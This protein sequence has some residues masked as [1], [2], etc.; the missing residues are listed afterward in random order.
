MPPPASLFARHGATIAVVGVLAVIVLVQL[1]PW[2]TGFVTPSPAP[3]F[4]V[5]DV[6][7][8]TTFA[9]ADHRGKIVLIDFTATWCTPCQFQLREL[10]QL[11]ER[12]PDV[13]IV[14]L[15]ASSET[16]ATVRAY[17][18][19]NDSGWTH[20]LDT[21]GVSQRYGATGLPTIVLVDGDGDIR[22]FRDGVT[23][24]GALSDAVDR[25]RS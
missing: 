10:Q 16:A 22:F 21:D 20:A 11:S 1:E 23:N 9:L 18:K 14:S 3:E 7:D 17:A 25:L 13:V 4:S 24:A 6:R 12:R 19:E 2:D 15:A 5:V 8:G